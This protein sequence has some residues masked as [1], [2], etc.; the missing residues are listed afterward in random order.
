[1]DRKKQRRKTEVSRPQSVM[2]KARPQQVCDT[3]DADV[4]PPLTLI[5]F[6]MTQCSHAVIISHYTRRQITVLSHTHAHT[7]DFR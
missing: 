3:V 6:S 2:D 1:M 7:L 5:I 4:S